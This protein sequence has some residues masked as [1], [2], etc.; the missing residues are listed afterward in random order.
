MNAFRNICSVKPLLDLV[1]DWQDFLREGIE[2]KENQRIR[3][4]ERTGRPLGD[5]SFIDKIE[6]AAARVLRKQKPGPRKDK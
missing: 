5:K 6:N 3:S 4:H 1:P 2:E